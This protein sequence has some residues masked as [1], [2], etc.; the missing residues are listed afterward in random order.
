[1]LEV[2]YAAP[3]A[4]KANGYAHSGPNLAKYLEAEGIR[5]VPDGAKRKIGLSYGYPAK[6]REIAACEKRVIF[7]MFESDEI[8]PSWDEWLVMADLIIVPSDFCAQAF[9]KR[10]WESKLVPLGIEHD[11]WPPVKRPRRRPLTFLQYESCNVRKGFFELFR[12]FRVAF[13]DDPSFR[14]IFKTTRAE[15]A[16]PLHEYPNM[17]VRRGEYTREEMHALLAEADIFVFPS[18]GEGFGHTPLEALSSGLP[19][20][21]PNAH[22]IATYWNG[23]LMRGF[24]TY[25]C[26]ARY[27][28]IKEPVGYYQAADVHDLARAMKEAA[29]WYMDPKTDLWEFAQQAHAYA[30]QWT[31]RRTAK[32]LAQHIFDLCS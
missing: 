3:T 26:V 11:L 16:L 19:V 24:K 13:G 4:Q 9:A 31:Y 12:A 32:I 7:S 28:H 8:P 21:A 1:M 2:T 27:D 10:G 22:G 20:I 14:I 29:A 23:E 6:V 30:S 5:L 25:P 15:N 17:E 18:R